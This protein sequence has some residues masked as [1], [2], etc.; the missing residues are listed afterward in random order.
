LVDDGGR[1]HIRALAREAKNLE[2]ELRRLK[3]E[4]VQ[5][6]L[7]LSHGGAALRVRF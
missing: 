6:Q 3:W 1:P 4:R 5:P 7:G 2:H